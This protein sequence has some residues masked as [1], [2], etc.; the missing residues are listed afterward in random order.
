M[1]VMDIIMD[2]RCKFGKHLW[3]YYYEML[4]HTEVATK[5]YRICLNCDKTVLVSDA[6]TE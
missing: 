1:K 2:I 3:Y 6:F 4:P 5:E